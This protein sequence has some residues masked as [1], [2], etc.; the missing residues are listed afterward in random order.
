MN[1]AKTVEICRHDG[2]GSLLVSG[3]K[4]TCPAI[5]RPSG[6]AGSGVT[7]ADNEAGKAEIAKNRSDLKKTSAHQVLVLIKRK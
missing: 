5:S 2:S 6:G 1:D 7:R 4:Q 3:Q